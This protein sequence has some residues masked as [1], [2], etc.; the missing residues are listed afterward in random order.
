MA[1]LLPSEGYLKVDEVQV[2][3]SNTTSW[4]ALIS[5]V[6]Q[7]IFILEKSVAHNIAFGVP[8]HDIDMSRVRRAAKQAQLSSFIEA[9]PNKYDSNMGERGAKLSGGQKQRLGIARAYYRD[10]KLIV[11]DEITN[12]LDSQTEMEVLSAIYEMP[13][14]V[15][16]IIIT[17]KPDT[18]KNCSKIIKL[19]DSSLVFNG[20]WNDLTE[21][22]LA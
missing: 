17:H 10:A 18:L 7:D 5:H 14:T 9:L 1:L 22:D 2:S 8:D 19:L 20:T 4:Q 15:T 3:S 6:S 13:E 12:A 11:F 21:G 16:V